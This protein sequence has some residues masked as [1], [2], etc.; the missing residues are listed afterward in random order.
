VAHPARVAVFHDEG[1]STALDPA[2]V[3]D[4]IDV[5]VTDWNAQRRL[6]H[7]L[8][9]LGVEPDRAIVMGVDTQDIEAARAAEVELAVGVARGDATPERLRRAG[10][11]AV[12]ADPQELLEHTAG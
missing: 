8:E 6:V 5:V 4:R 7:A 2:A 9:E 12:V 11:V 10:A 1:A 3:T